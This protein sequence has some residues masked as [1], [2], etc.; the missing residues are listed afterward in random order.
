MSYLQNKL[1]EYRRRAQFAA[2]CFKRADSERFIRQVNQIGKEGNL[3][4]LNRYGD[5]IPKC[6]VY[7]IKPEYS[8]SGFFADHSH[9]LGLLYF[10]D[11]FG[12]EPVVE[13]PPDHC[14]AEKHPVNG[15]SNPFEYYYQQPGAVSLEELYCYRQVICSRKENGS[16]AVALKENSNGYSI[17]EKYIQEMGRITRKY[18]RLQP[19]VEGYIEESI[20]KLA[21][22][23]E[24]LLGIHFRGTDFKRN[25]NGHPVSL[26]VEDYGAV[27]DSLLDKGYE[28][29]F[30]ATDDMEALER[31]K[32]LYGNKLVF[33]EDV[34]RSTEKETVMKSVSERTEHHYR[35][36]LEVLR[37]MMMLAKCDSLIAGLS[38]VSIAARIQKASRS[39]SYRELIVID[40]GINYHKKE[41]CAQ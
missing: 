38:Q 24:Q 6:R 14:Y 5:T 25:Y 16:Y 9:L 39:E 26:T 12:L 27:I 23:N 19:E 17:T 20:Q 35:L 2:A 29:L 34:I 11:Y 10:A 13:Y 21:K 36:G 28:K 37:D 1:K 32:E 40:K 15:R 7:H 31:F 41:N 18:L 33:F 4:Y 30:I 8:G 3:V 22:G